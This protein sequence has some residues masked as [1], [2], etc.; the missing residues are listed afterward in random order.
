MN[1][2]ISQ[3]IQSTLNILEE[4]NSHGNNF[5]LLKICG[6]SNSEVF[7]HTPILKE[8]LDPEG[9]HGQKDLFL[10]SFVE[11]FKLDFKIRGNIKTKKEQRFND[12]G[13][14]DLMI[15]NEEQIIILEN[16]IYAV[17]QS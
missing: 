2:K 4:N 12:Y 17:D 16:K 8:L 6:V 1:S 15:E 10:K 7:T 5:N 9:T 3:I 11:F 13:Q 14:I